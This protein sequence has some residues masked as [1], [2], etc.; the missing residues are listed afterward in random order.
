MPG[1]LIFALCFLF[2]SCGKQV[3]PP[4]TEYVLGT[5]CSV[6][7]YDDGTR[8]N[9]IDVFKRLNEIDNEFNVNKPT[10]DI[11]KVNSDAG[12]GP[13]AVKKEVYELVRLSKEI[14][15]ATGETFNPAMGALINLWGIGKDN[16]RVPSQEEIN[17]AINHCRPENV[18]LKEE[19]GSYYIEIKDEKTALDLGAIVK[20]FASDELAAMMEERKIKRAVIDLGGNIY[21]FG[22][23]S[24]SNPDVLWKVGIRNPVDT[25]SDPVET[26]S[27]RSGS[28]VTSG[29][30]ERYF[31][32]NGKR[33]HHII[34]GKT[35]W[36]ADSSIAS[37]TVVYERSVIC[38]ALATACF[39]AGGKR[40]FEEKLGLKG[41]KF[42]W[43]DDKG[44]LT[45]R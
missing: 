8:E 37:V 21:C 9:Y 6:N 7:L 11:S 29:N 35:G 19:N 2:A 25:T 1:I 20:G 13:V 3:L 26:V 39:V 14:S 31:I 40:D 4:Q 23:K 38:D 15:L 28:V 18:Q 41:I 22:Q 36:P 27:I 34:D 32:E 12:H 43:V 30:Y 44:K 17:E 24:S 42:I 45:E 5:V 33:Y 16:Q 10:S